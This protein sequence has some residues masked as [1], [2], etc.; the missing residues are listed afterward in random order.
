MFLVYT[1]SPFF[2]IIVLFCESLLVLI[3]DFISVKVPAATPAVTAPQ[4]SV[5][6][7]SVPSVVGGAPAAVTPPASSQ[8]PPL[9]IQVCVLNM[10]TVVLQTFTVSKGIG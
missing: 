7:A 2:I 6:S 8:G 3:H 10:Y 1:F 4:T 5:A 9:P